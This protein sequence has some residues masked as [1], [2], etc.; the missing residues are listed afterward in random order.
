MQNSMPRRSNS[1]TGPKRVAYLW[2]AGA[3][4]AEISYL[5]AHSV[6]LLMQD[7][8]DLGEGVATR[9]LARLS[10]RWRSSFSAEN[11]MDIEKLISL[12]DAS[13]V[14]AYSRLADTIRRLYFEDIRDS[15]AR[16]EVLQN[17]QL[18]IALLTMHSNSNFMRHEILSGIITTNHDGLLQLA[19]QSVQTDVNIGIPFRSQEF[20]L[21]TSR[22]PPLLHLHGSFTWSFGLPIRVSSLS[23]TSPYSSKTVWIPPTTLKETKSYPFNKLAGL[24]YELL[25]R[26]CD[27][28]R[29]VGSALTQNDWNILSMI[30]NAQRHSEITKG[31]PFRVELIIPNSAGERLV[32]D[33]AYLK[34]LNPLIYLTDGDFGDCDENNK[35]NFTP[36]ARNP[37]AYWMKR[38]IQ[39]HLDSGDFGDQQVDPRIAQITGDM[40]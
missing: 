1:S 16:A 25:S 5:G 24:A 2:G 23:E 7:H 34:N 4:Q 26:D 37:L 36:E 21:S 30:F 40:R 20:K 9:I 13:N 12:L 28:L 39:F 19:A 33:C 32:N 14:A 27:V 35:D 8:A 11:G 22:K 15:L 31:V 10:D 29:V 17:P 3:T 6:N 38:K 18:A